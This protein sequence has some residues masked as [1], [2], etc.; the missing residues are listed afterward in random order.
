MRANLASTTFLANDG[1]P[2]QYGLIAEELKDVLPELVPY[3]SDGQPETVMYHVLPTLLVAEVQRL[4][5][6]RAALA[7]RLDA[8]EREL[9][10]VRQQRP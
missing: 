5:R 2:I 3:G 4:E 10:S 6:E 9:A 7:S 1:S 8:L